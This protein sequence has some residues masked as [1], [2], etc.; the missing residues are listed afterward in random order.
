MPSPVSEL[1]GPN[2]K[3]HE[4]SFLEDYTFQQ[5]TPY[6][7]A[8]RDPVCNRVTLVGVCVCV[9]LC[10]LSR[11]QTNYD[12]LPPTLWSVEL[13]CILESFPPFWLIQM[14]CHV[15]VSPWWRL[16]PIKFV[17]FFSL[18]TFLETLSDLSKAVHRNNILNNFE[19]KYRSCCFKWRSS[20]LSTHS[21]LIDPTLIFWGWID[22]LGIF[23]KLECCSETKSDFE[24]LLF[25]YTL[26]KWN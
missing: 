24:K 3:H 2:I 7:H 16:G 13:V 10:V 19:A 14:L 11:R 5:A 22:S 12:C 9:C 6:I 1:R 4:G 25:W 20:C 18:L 17:S 23:S 8:L 26:Q 21:L 15:I